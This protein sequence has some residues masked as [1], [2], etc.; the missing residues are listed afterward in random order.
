[1]TECGISDR[2]VRFA[3]VL[4]GRF[5][6]GLAQ[7]NVVAST[8]FGGISGSSVAD[9]ASIGSFL[10]PSMKKSNYPSG[11]A[12]SVTITSSVQGVLIPPSQNM[13]YFALASGGLPI[14]KLFLAGYVPG[15]IL[16]T[17]L[18]VIC[19]VMAVR[20]GHPVGRSYS[21]GEAWQA[22]VE[23]FAG[24]LTIIIIIGGILGGVFTVTES[25]AVAAV[26]AALV[27]SLYYRTMN[28]VA[29]KNILRKTLTSLAMVVA[30]IAFSAA[31]GFLLSFLQIPT[32][33]ADGILGLSQR[34]WIVLIAVNVLLLLVGMIMDMGVVILL[35]T[36]ILLP[37]VEKVGVD[38]IHF[39]IIM[40]LNLGLGLCT[41]PVGVSLLVGC[42]IGRT[43]LEETTRNLLPF[44]VAMVVVLLL[45]TFF[46]A[47]SM[48]LPNWLG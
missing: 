32:L 20:N 28:M 13:I 15:F 17:S 31:F 1:M 26:Y 36:P 14:G 45:V 19:W 16:A 40:L 37:I 48:T 38:P 9:V 23:A 29:A 21:R 7:G 41:P 46:P 12:V 30:I 35:L 39:G 42:G 44:Y 33:L 3:N 5:R 11:Y 22:L 10:I 2:L 27:A 43:S 47:L 6:G 24:L 25:A 18:V 34:P 8:F 4:V